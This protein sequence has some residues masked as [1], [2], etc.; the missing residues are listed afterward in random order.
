MVVTQWVNTLM[1]RACY[2]MLSTHF[3]TWLAGC[4]RLMIVWYLQG[5]QGKWQ[6]KM[7]MTVSI[8]ILGKKWKGPQNR[9][10][11]DGLKYITVPT[12]NKIK[13]EQTKPCLNFVIF[14]RRQRNLWR[15]VVTVDF[16][17]AQLYNQSLYSPP[18]DVD[19]WKHSLVTTN[20][21]RQ[22]LS[23][24]TRVCVRGVVWYHKQVGCVWDWMVL[25]PVPLSDKIAY[26]PKNTREIEIANAE[27]LYVDIHC[28]S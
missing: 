12:E 28:T 3:W 10:I 27:D 24:L 16:S 11:E 22:S 20:R 15:C 4:L 21:N 5:P 14:D 26:W 7:Y 13:H 2:A 23:G 8:F 19:K 18:E 17:P 25:D 9:N 6:D 1:R